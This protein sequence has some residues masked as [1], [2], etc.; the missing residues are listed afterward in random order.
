[1]KI[2][3]KIKIEK[4]FWG[5]AYDKYLY[6]GFTGIF[7]K[8]NQKI[9]NHYTKKNKPKIVMEFGG[10]GKP[11]WHWMDKET[12]KN[13]ESYIIVD[14]KIYLKK[15]KI[16]KDLQHKKVIKIHFNNEKKINSYKNKVDR[17]IASHVLEHI[18]DP[19]NSIINWINLLNKNG[20]IS[21]ALPCD[22]GLLYRLGQLLSMRKACNIYKITRLEKDLWQ[23]REHINAL[24]KLIFILNYYFKKK[25]TF[26]FPFFLPIVDI[27]IFYFAELK[28]KDVRF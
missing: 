26:W 24:Q 5:T 2:L 22:P 4:K 25:K 6:K 1:M 19:E 10:A 20:S 8:I 27:N 3:K 15:I 23:S 11:N 13:I 12:L 14:D 28:K 21:L 17:I 7:M 9:I 18:P 16:P